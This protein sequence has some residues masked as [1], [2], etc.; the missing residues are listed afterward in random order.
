MIFFWP[1][2]DFIFFN[3][4][5]NKWQHEIY[6]KSTVFYEIWKIIVTTRITKPSL[7]IVQLF[8]FYD[9]KN[10]I[11]FRLTLYREKGTTK[12][13]VV[14]KKSAHKTNKISIE[15]KSEKNLN[16]FTVK[17]IIEYYWKFLVKRI[18]KSAHKYSGSLKFELVRG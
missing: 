7:F 6:E 8:I 15:P 10:N 2:L 5:M 9:K 4:L 13:I 3:T 14:C 11:F 1:I 16:K 12:I 18:L 17:I